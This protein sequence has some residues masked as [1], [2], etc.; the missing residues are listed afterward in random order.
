MRSH[1]QRSAAALAV[2]AL[3]LLPHRVAT[4]ELTTIHVASIT[5]DTCSAF[6]YAMKL[7]LFK[8]AGLSIDF[9]P[10]DS[11]AAT[12]A[13][14]VGGSVQFAQ[15]S[16]VTL[17]TAHTR[18]VPFTLIAPGGV[19]TAGSPY[20]GTIVRSDSSIKSAA[21]L[22]GKTFA[23]AALQD[24]NQIAAMDWID[25][26]GGDSKTVKFI[27]LSPRATV[28]AIEE[29]RVDAGQIGTPFLS[30]A[31]DSGKTRLLSHIFDVFGKR[32]ENVGWFTTTD[33]ARSHPEIVSKF[34]RVMHEAN[35]LANAHHAET[36]ALLAEYLKGDPAIYAHMARVQFGEY[37]DPREIQPL[38]DAAAKYKA[39]EHPFPAREM[40]SP[41]A[42]RPGR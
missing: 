16:L 29:G 11:G 2:A 7:G 18:G 4:Q 9:L 3:S 20:A 8:K 21:D 27:E 35:L 6:L 28:S 19:I 42:L 37:L 17:I 15:S 1:L 34:A 24:L 38:I 32:F 40:I 39:I 10:M 36:A 30:V 26:N 12:S 22:N 41:L 23:V 13:A 14:L 5:N 25:A 31:L 33:Y